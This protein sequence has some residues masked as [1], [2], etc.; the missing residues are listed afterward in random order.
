MKVNI[1]EHHSITTECLEVQKHMYVDNGA[2]SY[3]NHKGRTVSQ[4]PKF[5]TKFMIIHTIIE[6]GA[7]RMYMSTTIADSSAISTASV[8]TTYSIC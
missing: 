5:N 2:F 4:Q 7:K 6:T 3:N 8:N 1:D